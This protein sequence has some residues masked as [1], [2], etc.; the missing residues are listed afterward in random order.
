METIVLTDSFNCWEN[1][2]IDI[3]IGLNQSSNIIKTL[4]C[5][6]NSDCDIDMEINDDEI[7]CLMEY[8]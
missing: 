5:Y 8:L 7:D 2:G 4:K 3:N 1:N 6:N